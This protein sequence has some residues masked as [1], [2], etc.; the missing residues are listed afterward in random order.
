MQPRTPPSRRALFGVGGS[1]TG[2]PLEGVLEH[3]A[4][5]AS[6][7]SPSILVRLSGGVRSLLGKRSPSEPTAQ[8]TPGGGLVI[9]KMINVTI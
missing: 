1:Q 7:A 6:P 9:L 5:S 4:T 2:S 3:A 8:T